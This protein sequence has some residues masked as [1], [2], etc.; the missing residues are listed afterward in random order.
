[1]RSS[2][3]ATGSTAIGSINARPSRC[4]R[5]MKRLMP[6]LPRSAPP[7]A[8]GPARNARAPAPLQHSTRPA[9]GSR[10]SR[11]SPASSSR[12]IR[13]NRGIA[14]GV[15]DTSCTPSPIRNGNASTSE[16]M[17]PH[18]ETLLPCASPAAATARM[19]R[20]TAGCNASRRSASSAWPRSM[21]SVYCERSLVPMGKVI[22]FLRELVG[23]ERR[24]RR[25]PP[26]RRWAEGL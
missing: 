16:P 1:M 25:P 19:R 20:S 9:L 26:S 8:R 4:V 6:T 14:A 22:G 17:A 7:R 13:F 11:H 15:A 3:P 12:T 5:S 18:T 21:A 24:R 10:G 23:E 2:R